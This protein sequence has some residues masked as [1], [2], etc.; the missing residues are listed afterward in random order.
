MADKTDRKV[1]VMVMKWGLDQGRNESSTLSKAVGWVSISRFPDERH[2]QRPQRAEGVREG[3]LSKQ[4][5]ASEKVEIKQRK[6]QETQQTAWAEMP[7]RIFWDG[8]NILY[9]CSHQPCWLL[10]T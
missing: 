4:R 9:P 2:I 3:S 5:N 7:A 6:T 8:G 10:R 1:E